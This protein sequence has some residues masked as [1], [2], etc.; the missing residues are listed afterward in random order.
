MT[1]HT[2]HN[3]AC[4]C[5]QVQFRMTTAPL[6]VHCCHCS[7][8]QRE[9][10]ASF[11]LNALIESDRLEVLKGGLARVEI[12]SDSGKGQILVKC[13]ECLV[14]LWSHYAGMG[15]QMSFVRVG[16]LDNPSALPPDVHIFTSTKQPW[17]TLDDSTPV[18]AEYYKK[19]NVWRPDAI[20]RF[21]TLLAKIKGS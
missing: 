18:M 10:G 21:K 11:A 7:W 2:Q 6:V 12:P 14:T 5:G 9:S 19:A 4:T 1:D 3:G 20:E 17:I 15:E 13:P 16:T 8:C